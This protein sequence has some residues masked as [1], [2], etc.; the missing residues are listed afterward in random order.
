MLRYLMDTNVLS[1]PLRASPNP[2]IL[3]RLERYR[4]GVA[5]AAP[6]WHEAVFGLRRLPPSRKRRA[7]EVYLFEVLQPYL[8]IL[9]YDREASEWHAAERARLEKAG[10]TPPFFDGQIAA[11]ARVNDLVVVTN[12]VADFKVFTEINVE[13]WRA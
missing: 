3:E 6:V 2:R 8:I 13:D 10:K 7:I 4:E 11:I 1:E 5:T 9:P 12:N